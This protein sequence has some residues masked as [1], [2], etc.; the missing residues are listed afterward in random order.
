MNIKIG[1]IGTGDTFS[2]GSYHAKAIRH[3]NNATLVGIYNRTKER[4]ISFI[5]EHN[6]K[7]AHPYTSY[8]EL[9]DAIDA[10][11]ICTPSNAHTPFV[12]EAI[13][14]GK[15]ILVEKPIT[16][17]YSECQ[18]IMKALEKN[19]VFN[20]VGFDM[21]FSHQVI[22]FKNLIKNHMGNIYNLSI[23]YGGL[24]IANP[25][26]PFEW[27]MDKHLSG[28][29]ALQDFGSHMLDFALYACNISIK[30][31]SSMIQTHIPTRIT[32]EQQIRS[33]ENDDSC[34]IT[35]IGEK[36]ELCSFHMSRVGFNEFNVIV[37]GEGGLIKMS[38]SNNHIEFLPKQRDGGYQ[39]KVQII[40]TKETVF[41]TR[42]HSNTRSSVY[43][44]I[45]RK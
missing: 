33:V 22:A 24:R 21:R 42:F 32:Q 18:S 14:K 3:N 2:I 34:I 5:A 15:A 19:P 12:L 43:R 38:L 44:R 1:L 6:L 35:G 28:Y 7:E 36:G 29:G 37:S 39:S 45:I 8:E 20:M 16:S 4:S 31:V 17:T 40:E 9:L 30:E 41:H 11:I 25:N 23:T 10:I 13:K 27:R 26:L